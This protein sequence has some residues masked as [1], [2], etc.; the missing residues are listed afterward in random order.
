MNS[1][2]FETCVRTDHYVH[3]PD[4]LPVGLRIRV[5]IE[6]LNDN[7]GVDPDQPHS[8]IRRLA[9]AARQAYIAS[10]GKLL[11]AD[12]ISAEVRRRRGGI[13]DE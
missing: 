8:E 7:P 9:L 1:L 6:P 12:E 2:T 5:H 11:S 4:E 13:S 3:L 10:G